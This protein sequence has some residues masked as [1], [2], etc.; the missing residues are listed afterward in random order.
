MT[1]YSYHLT[2]DEYA[3]R[4]FATLSFIDAQ[5][6]RTVLRRVVLRARPN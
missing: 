6:A 3:P 4:V 5:T 2:E 1:T